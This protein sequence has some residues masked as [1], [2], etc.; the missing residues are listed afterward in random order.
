MIQVKGQYSLTFSLGS[1]SDL[2]SEEELEVF[3]LIEE[4]GNI[5]PTFELIVCVSDDTLITLLTENITVQVSYGRSSNEVVTSTL[6]I[7]RADTVPVGQDKR[8]V[9]L[10]GVLNVLEYVN[11]SNARIISGTAVDVLREV[12]STHFRVDS[13][14]SSEDSQNW[15]QPG[16]SDRSFVQNVWLHSNIPS[17]VMLLALSASGV[18][19]IRDIR[20]LAGSAPK[21]S[22]FHFGDFGQE[23]NIPYKGDPL[24][25]VH[26]GILNSWYGNPRTQSVVDLN[27]GESGTSLPAVELL[28]NSG[29]R[30]W[31]QFSRVNNVR[32]ANDNVHASYWDSYNGNLTR[33]AVLSTVKVRVRFDDR[34]RD[35]QLL[36]LVSFSAESAIKPIAAGALSGNYIVTKVVRSL[37][38]KK[39]TTS[40][41]LV[42]E[43]LG[44]SL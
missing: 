2:F 41:E 9:I 38:A 1:K 26:Q 22:F 16:S 36:D 14:V 13:D 6:A 27:S 37:S 7:A 15:I 24:V 34:F 33:L 12:L 3:N 39:F 17:S 43:Q 11:G 8:R 21:W 5:L 29:V 25:E 30:L 19:K 20:K 31:Q 42:R 10:S 40:V 23:K 35:I 32:V 44:G 4:A 18:A 28:L